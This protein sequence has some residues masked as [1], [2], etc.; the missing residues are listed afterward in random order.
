VYNEMKCHMT[1][2]ILEL[3]NEEREGKIINKSLVK[4][5]VKIYE[6]MGMGSLRSYCNDLEK[7]LF[8]S[9][10]E[11][12]GK[13]R[14]DWI[15]DSTPNYLI[16]VE[17]A[18]KE[19]RNRKAAYLNSSSETKIIKVVEKEILEKAKMVCWKTSL[20]VAALCCGL[21]SPKICSV[22][23]IYSRGWKLV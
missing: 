21:T 12:Y 20:L 16:K 13:K 19:E 15:K 18:F 9:T 2:T 1:N 17:K 7:P 10:R 5:I 3:I 6:T 23:S 8:N 11:Y 4:S 22:C 14:K